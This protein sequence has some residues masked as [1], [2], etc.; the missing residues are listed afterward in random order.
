MTNDGHGNF[1]LTPREAEVLQLMLDGLR[2]R[3]IGAALG[4]SA[5]TVD[6]YAWLFFRAFGCRN[7]KDLVDWVGGLPAKLFREGQARRKAA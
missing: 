6:R 5:G 7:R 2:S 1:Q 4:I 3:Q